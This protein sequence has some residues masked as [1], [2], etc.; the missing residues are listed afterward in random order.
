MI[1]YLIYSNLDIAC[2]V[3]CRCFV[4]QLVHIL[5]LACRVDIILYHTACEP[6]TGQGKAK[7]A[8]ASYGKH[9]EA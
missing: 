1:S 9:P 8:V 4:S 5:V 2:G 7:Y 6:T 3:C